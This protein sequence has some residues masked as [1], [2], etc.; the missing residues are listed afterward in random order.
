MKRTAETVQ[1]EWPLMCKHACDRDIRVLWV[2]CLQNL[3]QKQNNPHTVASVFCCCQSINQWMDYHIQNWCPAFKA[4]SAVAAASLQMEVQSSAWWASLFIYEGFAVN[5]DAWQ[6][7]VL[8]C[9]FRVPLYG[10]GQGF[11]WKNAP[12][13]FSVMRRRCAGPWML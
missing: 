4:A 10:L 8:A 1:R 9:F 11:K 12:V 6:G 5:A 3:Q 2:L 13:S 7:S